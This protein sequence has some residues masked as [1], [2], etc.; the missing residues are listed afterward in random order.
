MSYS[1]AFLGELVF[2]D[3]GQEAWL[4]S[5]PSPSAFDDWPDALATEEDDSPATIEKAI[6][7]LG[8][9]EP[10]AAAKKKKKK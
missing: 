5:A 3:G 10:A 2:A 6:A 8:G 1:V 7:A 9:A 4:E